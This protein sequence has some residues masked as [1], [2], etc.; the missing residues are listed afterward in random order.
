[1]TGTGRTDD[2]GV[3]GPIRGCP[4]GFPCKDTG[5]IGV[6]HRTLRRHQA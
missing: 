1:M 2:V 5:G 3:A 4:S 6:R